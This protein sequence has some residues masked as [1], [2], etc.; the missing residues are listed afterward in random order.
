M[1]GALDEATEGGKMAKVYGM[2]NQTRK[3]RYY[4][5]TTKPV[6]KRLGEHE[7]G[8]TAALRN[9]NWK[10][11]KIMVKT[12]AKGVPPHKAT[13]KAHELESRKPPQGWKN[14]QTGGK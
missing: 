10:G 1:D 4:G 8:Q 3:E 13:E 6:N 14:L 2:Y 11:D 5:S 12:V 9:W 7:T